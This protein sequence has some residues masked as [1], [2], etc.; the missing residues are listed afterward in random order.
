MGRATIRGPYLLMSPATNR[1][2]S[3]GPICGHGNHVESVAPHG[4]LAS[5]ASFARRQDTSALRRY[6][7]ALLFRGESFRAETRPVGMPN[8]SSLK[9]D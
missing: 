3:R 5:D 7:V 4:A 1:A 6:K 9:V 8:G 2:A